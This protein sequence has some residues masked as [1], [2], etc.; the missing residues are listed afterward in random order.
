[1]HPR[2]KSGVGSLLKLITVRK[3]TLNHYMLFQL[4]KTKLHRDRMFDPVTGAE[5]STKFKNK[6]INLIDAQQTRIP[7]QDNLPKNKPLERPNTRSNELDKTPMA[8]LPKLTD[9]TPKDTTR[10]EAPREAF[11]GN[12]T[13]YSRRQ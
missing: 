5:L 11:L 9:A 2:W 8:K 12:S 10:T 7:K 1:M 4:T 3:V 13:F 6:R